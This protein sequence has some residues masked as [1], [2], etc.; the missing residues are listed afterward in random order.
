MC[1]C[2]ERF[3]CFPWLNRRERPIE[4]RAKFASRAR[5]EER[6][7]GKG[8]GREREGGQ[9]SGG[10]FVEEGALVQQG[11]RSSIGE[12]KKGDKGS[13]KGRDNRVCGGEKAEGPLVLRISSRRRYRSRSI[14]VVYSRMKASRLVSTA[15]S[16]GIM[17]RFEGFSSLSRTLSLYSFLGSFRDSPLPVHFFPL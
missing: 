1:A 5:E 15:A 6:Q 11:P 3:E 9:K 16:K 4:S 14:S 13:W 8:E 17:R 10:C 2:I 12:D 7:T